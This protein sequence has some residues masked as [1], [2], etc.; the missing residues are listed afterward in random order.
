MI[1][2]KRFV[3]ERA[4]DFITNLKR[5]FTVSV[6]NTVFTSSLPCFTMTSLIGYWNFSVLCTCHV[7]IIFVNF[8]FF[9]SGQSV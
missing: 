4:V 1:S 3:T 9:K 7:Y 2:V 5:T 6:T 8:F